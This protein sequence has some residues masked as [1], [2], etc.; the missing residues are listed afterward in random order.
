MT[1]T[2]S[3][4]LYNMGHVAW[5]E[6]VTSFDG[7][8]MVQS[9]FTFTLTLVLLIYGPNIG[10]HAGNYAQGYMSILDCKGTCV[11]L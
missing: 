7:F 10:A 11:T 9:S 4:A 3:S 2:T 5:S 1:S 8:S 6:R